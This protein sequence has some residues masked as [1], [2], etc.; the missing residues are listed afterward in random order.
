MEAPDQHAPQGA[1]RDNRIAAPSSPWWAATRPQAWGRSTRCNGMSG[2][3][4]DGYRRFRNRRVQPYNESTSGL[5]A[6]RALLSAIICSKASTI[7]RPVLPPLQWA[8]LSQH[9]AGSLH[10]HQFKG[11]REEHYARR[12]N[13]NQPLFLPRPHSS[14]AAASSRAGFAVS[15]STYLRLVI[16]R[17]PFDGR[18]KRT[19]KPHI[20]RMPR[21]WLWH[22]SRKP[23][24][25]LKPCD[26]RPLRPAANP[27]SG[28]GRSSAPGHFAHIIS[29]QVISREAIC[30][31]AR[32][33][34]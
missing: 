2:K 1:L 9:V 20:A 19:L 3:S 5:P 23:P 14:S 12:L 16:T 21:A 7:R 10:R 24:D 17:A 34:I 28:L 27:P 15:R 11:K 29:R 8:P 25:G 31:M 30:R 22:T 26:R 13:A 4:L 32:A 18:G 33:D 6:Y